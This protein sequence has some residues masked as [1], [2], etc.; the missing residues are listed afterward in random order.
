MGN[1]NPGS[2]SLGRQWLLGN[3]YIGISPEWGSQGVLRRTELESEVRL[4]RSSSLHREP[5]KI[6]FAENTFYGDILTWEHESGVQTARNPIG[7]VGTN[8][9]RAHR[10]HVFLGFLDMGYMNPGSTHLKNPLIDRETMEIEL[11][12][13]KFL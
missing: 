3:R 1:S 10:K 2:V 5:M 6:E 4:L 9:N 13:N 8:R 7:Q 12:K 11:A